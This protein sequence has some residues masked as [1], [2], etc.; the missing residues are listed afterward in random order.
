MEMNPLTGLYFSYAFFDR[1]E[2]YL[3]QIEPDTHCMMAIDLEHFRLFNKLYGREQGDCLLQ[4]LA[5]LLKGYEQKHGGIVGYLGGD[6]F[7]MLVHYE[8]EALKQ[9]RRDI[10]REVKKWSSPVGFLPAFGIYPIVDTAE[11]AATMYDRATI[12][13]GHVLGNYSRRSCEYSEDMEEK[14]EEELRLLTEIQEAL[15]REEFTFYVQPQCDISTGKIVGGESLVRWQHPKKGLISPGMFIP[16]LERNGCIANLDRYVWK[17]VCMW[18][19]EWMDKG[20]HPVPLSI[21]VSRVD[22]FAMDVPAYLSELIQT[23]NIP[24]RLLKVEITE[25]AYAESNDKIIRTVKQLQDADFLIMMDDFGSGYSSLNMLKSI[26]VDVL[27]LDMRFLDINDQ[28]EER[29]IGILESVVNMARQMSMPIIVEGV[30]TKKQENYLLKMGCR[31]TQGYYYYKPMP[32]E[33]FEE[34]IYDEHN[35]DLDGMW[36]KQV[37]SLHLQELLDHNLFSDSMVNN[38]LGPA[39]FYEMYDNNIEI[40]RVNE[41]YFRLTG[42]SGKEAG[43]QNRKFWIHVRDDDRQ[44]LF[45]IFAQA[46]EN[47]ADGAQGYVHFQR[48]DGEVLWISLRVFFL[49][50]RE[51]RKLFYGSLTDMSSLQHERQPNDLLEQ[52]VDE[53]TENQHRHMVKYYGSLPCGY[54]VAR[55]ILDKEGSPRDY[56]I[57]YG[58]AE[59]SRVSGGNMDRLRF[60][61]NRAFTDRFQEMLQKA[62]QAAYLGESVEFSIY[63]SLSCRYLHFT[64][65]Q[66]QYGYLT[67]MLQ[68]VT[69]EFIYEN[70]LKN[71]LAPYKEVY[72]IHLQDNYYRMIYPDD[73]HLMERGNY[74]EAIE[75]HF[76]TG[77]ILD[78]DKKNVSDFL[79]LKNLQKLLQKQDS[80]EYRYQRRSADG[81]DEWCLNTVNVC[82]RV[83]G[84][85]KTA[86]MT[87]RSL[88]APVQKKERTL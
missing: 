85:P 38:I 52:E 71:I 17:R 64:L 83:D 6:N 2:E 12:A 16:V 49:R 15:E 11:S 46:Y 31:Y 47:Q 70:T 35:L 77:R 75:R 23:Y 42:I 86:I 66:Y 20:H 76:A 59:I 22:I 56:E 74:E 3:Q 51:G 7:C 13:L 10:T 19:R 67:C 14:M 61:A 37:E 24:P 68:D 40:T 32:I 5:E 45:S 39:A 63:S 65:G 84:V 43:E 53:L 82:E 60:L 36:C 30:E 50:E 57:V 48:A 81:G 58:N 54:A 44:L 26:S 69:H 78:Y 9:L 1:A 41:Q 80:A 33:E 29:G 55:V 21:N 72:F 73:H 28:E 8:K 18:L 25:S 79:T 87:I 34:L 62:Y 27:K 88:D 4:K